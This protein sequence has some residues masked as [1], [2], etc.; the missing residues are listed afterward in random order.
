MRGIDER[1]LEL[2]NTESVLEWLKRT[3]SKLKVE[4]FKNYHYILLKKWILS[5]GLVII[6][7]IIGLATGYFDLINISPIEPTLIENLATTIIAP[8]ITINGL[9]ITITPVISFFFLSEAKEMEKESRQELEEIKEDIGEEKEA[10]SEFENMVK[11]EHAFFYNLRC[12]I[13]NYVRTYIT[14]ALS[15]LLFLFMAYVLLNPPL[16][17]LADV[18]VVVIL[19]TGIFP[20]ISI[21]LYKPGLT[22]VTIFLRD[23]KKEI[24][25]Y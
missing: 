18:I 10:L 19:L 8:S 14:I 21:A 1:I 13:L 20:I 2:F 6:G 22:L 9:F 25:T 17:L 24:I 3:N 11:Y 4:A 23:G 12:G 15:S 7:L 16:F 5:L